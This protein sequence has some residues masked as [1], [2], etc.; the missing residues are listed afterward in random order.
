MDASA[1]IT[2]L[3]LGLLSSL[4]CLGMCAGIAGA[5]ALSLP[6]GPWRLLSIFAFNLGRLTSYGVAGALAGGLGGKVLGGLAP[7]TGNL[8][9]RLAAAGVLVAIGL[10]VAGWWPAL[11]RL[12][13]L[14]EPLWR[15]IEPLGRRL[16][17]AR[18]PLHALA[19]GAI[20]GWLPCGLVY[21]T[22]LWAGTTGGARSGFLTMIMFGLGTLPVMWLS[23]LFARSL[24]VWTRRPEARRVLGLAL[25]VAGLASLLYTGSLA[26]ECTVCGTP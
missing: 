12:E 23:G 4:H 2:A 15:A 9:L 24:A 20:W 18:T 17:P 21:S 16:L 10:Y 25:M 5:L 7:E 13:R 3:T 19:Y 8:V 26:P 6:A 22:L 11:G 1:L 14:G